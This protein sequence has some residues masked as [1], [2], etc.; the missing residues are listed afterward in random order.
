MATRYKSLSSRQIGSDS[1][2]TADPRSVKR[3]SRSVVACDRTIVASRK[4]ICLPT[5]LR[6]FTSGASKKY[7]EN[8]ILWPLRYTV[9]WTSTKIAAT[10]ENRRWSIWPAIRSR[11]NRPAHQPVSTPYQK[12]FL[13][14]DCQRCVGT[15]GRVERGRIVEQDARTNVSG[16]SVPES[17]ETIGH[18]WLIK[19]LT[20][21]ANENCLLVRRIRPEETLR[22]ISFVENDQSVSKQREISILGKIFDKSYVIWIRYWIILLQLQD[23]T[24]IYISNN[25]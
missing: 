2:T 5:N 16:K 22:E 6:A 20:I 3:S 24:G 17:K 25:S 1:H 23:C 11:T 7:D 10:R 9:Q 21:S 13:V 14:S 12:V 4:P 8:K 19:N 15:V 18:N